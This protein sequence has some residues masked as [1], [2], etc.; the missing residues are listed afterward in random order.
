MSKKKK[1]ERPKK[2]YAWHSCRVAPSKLE[3]QV[4]GEEIARIAAE[5]GGQVS[6][7]AIVDESRPADAVLHEEFEWDDAIAGEKFRQQQAG[8]IARS[9]VEV[10]IDPETQ[11]PREARAFVSVA[12]K[13]T[14]QENCRAYESIDAVLADEHKRKLHIQSCL[15][16]LVRA[17]DE[18]RNLNEFALV[19]E[20]IDD[21]IRKIGATV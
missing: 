1:D 12:V 16:R 19:W 11:H 14:N 17:R 7:Q 4:V 13:P 21:L 3:A 6:K 15:M 10:I 2:Q 18:Y 8:E 5:H 9:I 20:A